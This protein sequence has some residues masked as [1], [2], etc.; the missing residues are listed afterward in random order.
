MND[1][2]RAPHLTDPGRTEQTLKDGRDQALEARRT[3]RAFL[4]HTRHELRTPINAMIGYSEMLLED[5]A[6]RGQQD[7]IPDLQKIHTAGNQLLAL[8]NDILDPTK[9]EADEFDLDLET[10]GANLR[11]ALRTPINAVVGYSETLLEEAADRGQG[12]V[13]PD[14]QKI[15]A[16]AQRFLALI[17]DLVEFSPLNADARELDPQDSDPSA[18]RQEVVTTSRPPVDA[19]AATVQTDHGSLLVVDDHASNREM[20]S[21]RL[22]RRGYS[23]AVATDGHR[24]LKMLMTQTFDLVLLDI[25]MP[26]ISGLEV[27]RTLR[28]RHPMA[29]LPVIMATAKDQSGDIVE[30]LKLGANDYVTKPLDFPV[31]LARIQSQ[32]SLKRAMEEIQR[33]AK[34][35]ELRNQF[36][37]ATFGRYLTDEVVASVL[38]SPEGLKLGGETRQV[39]ILM[40]DLRGFTSLAGRLAPEQVVAILN[41]Y[42]GIMVDVIMRYQGTI[43]EFMGDAIF[44]IFGAPIWREDHAQRAVACAM[45]M[46]L[47]MTSVNAENRREGLPEVEMGIGVNT[48]EVVVGNI[49]SH[50]RTKYGVV[51]SHVNL[52]SRIESYTVGGQILIS[53]A[54]LQEAGPLVSVKAQ[55]Q[56]EAKGIDKPLSLYEVQGI[57]GEYNLVLPEREEALFPLPQEIPVR[58]TV[59]EGKHLGG[60][61]FEGSFVQLSG[62]GGEVRSEHPVAPRSDIKMRLMDANGEEL[63][64]DLY[65]KVVGQPMA[66]R[67]YFAVRFTSIP[68]A[69]ATFLQSLT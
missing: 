69:V 19:E 61:M 57:G 21:R 42:L 41:R 67:P 50:K 40:S 38:D 10:V 34:Q 62:K 32:L 47:A 5:A 36:I 2:A 14:L 30:A 20:L 37:R 35:L 53:E 54:T 1:H 44:V 15:H 49:G 29:D 43:D 3:R 7:L 68:P 12:D 25:M 31:V 11:H 28:E 6:D 17:N 23:V 48:G 39:T 58:Y 8:V 26:G 46:Q 45:A 18:M 51:G 55:M 9:L 60:T 24:A 13:I 65:G 64:G 22:A 16:A 52:T 27:L 4:A 59:L 33:L 56:V 66:T 63:S